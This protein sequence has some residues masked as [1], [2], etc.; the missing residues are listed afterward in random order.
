MENLAN[1]T[2]SRFQHYQGETLWPQLD[3]GQFVTLV[4]EPGNPY[5]DRAVRIDWQGHQLGYIPRM[6]NAAVSQLLDRGEK[7]SALIVGL[8]KSNNP[9]DRI[10]VE[11][12]WRA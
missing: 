7:L 1:L 10:M 6:D 4:R 2:G 3:A 8:K 9:W 11:V 5:D 12:Q